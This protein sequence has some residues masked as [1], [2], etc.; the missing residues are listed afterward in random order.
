MD[1]DMENKNIF[2]FVFPSDKE[3]N[4]CPDWGNKE[5][6]RDAPS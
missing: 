1:S 6:C 5:Y 4:P 2:F 3:Q